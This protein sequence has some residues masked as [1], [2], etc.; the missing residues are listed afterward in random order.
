MTGEPFYKS[1]WR[2]IDE[3]RMAAYRTMFRWSEAAEQLYAPAEIGEGQRVA[4]FGCGPGHTAIEFARRVGPAG[5]VHA[6]DINREF[7]TQ[8]CD[9]ATLAG[10]ETRISAQECDGRSLPLPDGA[11]DCVSARNAIMYVDDPVKTFRECRRVL[12]PG[13]RLHAIEGD[14]Y[15]MVME[16]VPHD[17]W[18]AFVKAAGHAC[19]NADMGRKLYGAARAA[20]FEDIRL[21]VIGNPDSEGRL[22]SMVTNMAKYA[23]LNG[24]LE[25]AA[26]DEVLEIAQ[27]AL[28][29]G[30][31][32]AVSPQFVMVG[33]RPPAQ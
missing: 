33:T 14:W 28:Q 4:D 31:Y 27:Q 13:G 12:R 20:G 19:R 10:L 18:R 23:R 6:L 32:L 15:M 22:L 1:H 7:L 29:D 2:D 25:E 26:I 3:D 16:P 11:L 9:N 21:Q 24:A 30:S 17:L 8:V 5:H